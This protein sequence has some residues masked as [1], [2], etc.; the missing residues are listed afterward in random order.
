MMSALYVEPMLLFHFYF[1][2]FSI[3]LDIRKH[4]LC[5]CLQL[6]NDTGF[7]FLPQYTAAVYFKSKKILL[8]CRLSASS[9]RGL[10]EYCING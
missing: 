4:V 6:D 9:Q 7:V 1:T 2:H 10:E 8:K 5:V 3:V